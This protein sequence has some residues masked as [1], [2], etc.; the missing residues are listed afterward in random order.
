MAER[1]EIERHPEVGFRI[2]SASYETKEIAECILSHHERWD[3]KGYPRGLAGEEIPLIS[4]I[5][6][7]ADAFDAMTAERPYRKPLTYDEIKSEFQNNAGTQ[8]D[9]QLTQLFIDRIL[10]EEQFQT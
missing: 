1:D 6:S 10:V 3:G 5:V 8:F 2:L 9:P 7:I 4:R